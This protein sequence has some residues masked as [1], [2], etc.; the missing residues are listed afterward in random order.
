MTASLRLELDSAGIDVCVVEPGAIAT[1]IWK[2]STSAADAMKAGL[3]ADKLSLYSEH[4]DCVSRV[5]ANAERQAISADAVADAV[6]HAL[7]AR[8]PRTHYLVGKD[9][10]LRAALA[11]VLPQPTLDF[12]HR[13]F[14]RFPRRR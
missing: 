6:E 2:K 10:K 14:L 8:R 1:P 11:A 4:I 9:A 3:A 13:W 7:T 12:M 5:I